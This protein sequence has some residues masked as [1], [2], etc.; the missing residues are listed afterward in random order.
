MPKMIGSR[1]YCLKPK[2]ETSTS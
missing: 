2:E 1:G